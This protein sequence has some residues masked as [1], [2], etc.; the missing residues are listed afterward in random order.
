M[1]ANAVW[2]CFHLRVSTYCGRM[3]RGMV[4]QNVPD[5]S[6]LM[7]NVNDHTKEETVLCHSEKLAITLGLIITRQEPVILIVKNE[8]R[9]LRLVRDSSQLHHFYNGSSSCGDH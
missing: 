5:T 9:L 2:R 6:M 8:G 3:I 7:Q 1:R 4:M